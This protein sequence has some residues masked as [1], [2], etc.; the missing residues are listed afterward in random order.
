MDKKKMLIIGVIAVVGI[1]YYMYNKSKKVST[2]SGATD[3]GTGTGATDTGTGATKSDEIKTEI[4]S[5]CPSK[6]DL[7]RKRYTKE[8]MDKFKAQGCK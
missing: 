7:K 1:G 4:I 6:E 2:G 3:T 8:Q 5:N